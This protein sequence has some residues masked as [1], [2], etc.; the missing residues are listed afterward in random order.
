MADVEQILQR[1]QSI[2]GSRSNWETHWE[3]IAE[4]V[5]PRQMGF[6]GA[7]TD[8]EKKTQKVFDSKPMIALERFAAVMD[9]M[10]TPRQQKWHNLRTTDEQGEPPEPKTCKNSTAT[11]KCR[12]GSTRSTTSCT[13]AAIHPKPTLLARTANAGHLWAHSALVRC[14]WTTSRAWA[15]AIAA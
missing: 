3:E 15:C 9:S 7:R 11:L 10:L 8:G 13:P 2:K 4:R 6:L 1:Y 12:T 14:L 5:L